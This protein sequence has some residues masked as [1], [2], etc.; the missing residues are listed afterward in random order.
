MVVVVVVVG[1]VV[2]VVVVV[3]VG[4]VVVVVVDI[5]GGGSGSSVALSVVSLSFSSVAEG[6]TISPGARLGSPFRAACS[7]SVCTE[8]AETSNVANTAATMRV[9][10]TGTGTPHV[11]QSRCSIHEM[12]R[13]A[14]IHVI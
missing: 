9:R 7:P 11:V 4:V 10:I 2:V 6:T 13:E 8:H 3:V 1:V 14:R 5:V 12:E